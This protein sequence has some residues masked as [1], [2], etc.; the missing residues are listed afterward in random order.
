MARKNEKVDAGA[1]P[2]SRAKRKGGRP[3]KEKG[4]PKAPR[5][6]PPVLGRIARA[7]RRGR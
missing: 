2:K 4:M 3:S 1:K 5:D 6:D 7:A